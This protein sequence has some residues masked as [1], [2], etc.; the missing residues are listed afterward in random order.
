MLLRHDYQRVDRNSHHDGGHTV[1]Y[2]G[3]KANCRSQP[4]AASEFGKENAPAD[5]DRDTDQAANSEQNRRPHDCVR[6]SPAKLA[7]GNRIAGKEVQI[8]RDGA[9][10]NQIHKDCHQRCDH[11]NGRKYRQP[12]RQ[13]IGQRSYPRSSFIF[14][15]Q[16]ELS[17]LCFLVTNCCSSQRVCA[18]APRVTAQT[19]IR[20]IALTMMVTTKSAKPI[21]INALMW[22]SSEASLNSFAITEAMV[23]P[24]A[25]MER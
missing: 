21:S 22:S 4:A 20:A 14:S 5:S 18:G 13:T 24:L 1:E 17:S 6:H 23:L 10:V 3:C 7:Y 2:I 12:A 11:Q 19:S 8:E 15:R 16:L 9:L 25:R